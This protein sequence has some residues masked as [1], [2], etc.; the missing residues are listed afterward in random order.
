MEKYV[1]YNYN[2][3]CVSF[4]NIAIHKIC[5]IM[6]QIDIKDIFCI[7]NVSKNTLYWI[8]IIST[9][10]NNVP[11]EGILCKWSMIYFGISM[12]IYLGLNRII[13]NGKMIFLYQHAIMDIYYLNLW[14]QRS[15]WRH[16]PNG[17]HPHWAVTML[18]HNTSIK[19]FCFRFILF[20]I[21]SKDE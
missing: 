9:C 5:I 20:G 10:E 17:R 11:F 18:Y 16:F 6:Y 12:Y 7:L 8:Y 4:L 19:K 14:K 15:I 3:C 13:I 1:I 21:F 2:S